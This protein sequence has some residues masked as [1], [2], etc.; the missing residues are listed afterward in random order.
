MVT[1]FDADG[2][3]GDGAP[4]RDA[5]LGG[6]ASCRVRRSE[7]LGIADGEPVDGKSFA[8]SFLEQI[9]SG[10]RALLL[11]ERLINDAKKAPAPFTASAVESTEVDAE[12]SYGREGVSF[13]VV[14]GGGF[15][16]T[17]GDR[18]DDGVYVGLAP[19]GGLPTVDN[20]DE[21]ID[22]FAAAAWVARVLFSRRR[23]HHYDESLRVR[24]S[25]GVRRTPSTPGARTAT[26]LDQPGHRDTGDGRLVAADHARR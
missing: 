19:S 10:T 18:R 7:A 20:M 26:R 21:D 4:Q 14:A 23:V 3:W 25:S 15:S 6:R 5:A 9:T 13:D 12:M 24:T 8:P 22:N 1:T 16:G 17:D 11:R 2:G